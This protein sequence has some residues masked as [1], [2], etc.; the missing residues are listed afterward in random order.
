MKNRFLTTS[1]SGENIDKSLHI[2][3]RSNGFFRKNINIK[4]VSADQNIIEEDFNVLCSDMNVPFLKN[5]YNFYFQLKLIENIEY[6]VCYNEGTNFKL[7]APYISDENEYQY[8]LFYNGV[9][10]K[11]ENVFNLIEILKSIDQLYSNL[12]LNLNNN[13]LKIC[14]QK[15][16]AI[17]VY[18]YQFPK[19]KFYRVRYFQK[20]NT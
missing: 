17:L 3:I 7:I 2:F 1:S 5:Q 18:Y 14:I 16:T 12:N 8:Y 13:D 19:K 9:T 20:K 11:I 15:Y 10:H 6:L 4:V